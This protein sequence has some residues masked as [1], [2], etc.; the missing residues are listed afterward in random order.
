[1]GLFDEI[2]N[3]LEEL[4][5]EGEQWSG[6]PVTPD[7]DYYLDPGSQGWLTSAANLVST[8]TLGR[9]QYHDQVIALLKHPHF[10]N[11][12]PETVVKR[13]V[14]VLRALQ[15]DWSRGLLRQVEYLVA[16]ETFD[17]FL[18]HAVR[19]HRGGLLRESGVLVSIVFEDAIRKLA[20][21]LGLNANADIEALIDEIANTGLIIT[22]VMARRLKGGPAALRNKALHAKWSEF[23]LKDVGEAIPPTREVLSLL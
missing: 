12:V 21:K 9:G 4:I 18:D 1:M 5:R 8:I 2:G 10:V 14:G 3:R 15:V 17:S 11:G 20:K 16:A 7:N 6:R 19:L 13:M 22:P 23:D